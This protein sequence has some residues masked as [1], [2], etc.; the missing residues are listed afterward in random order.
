MEEEIGGGL[1]Q[2]VSFNED[3]SVL[4]FVNI[5]SSV[6]LLGFWFLDISVRGRCTLSGTAYTNFISCFPCYFVSIGILVPCS[7]FL[8][9]FFVMQNY[10]IELTRHLVVGKI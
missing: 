6:S 10:E 8:S 9:A 7:L 4:V 1:G 5:M 2:R 3:Y